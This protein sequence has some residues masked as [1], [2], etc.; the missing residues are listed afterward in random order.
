[1]LT[2]RVLSQAR[3]KDCQVWVTGP[4]TLKALL[5]PQLPNVPRKQLQELQSKL[6]ACKVRERMTTEPVDT[7]VLD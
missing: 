7:A 5:L 3:S 6:Q 1:M 4:I 2:P